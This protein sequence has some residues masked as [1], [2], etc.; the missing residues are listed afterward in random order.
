MGSIK[1]CVMSRCNNQAS[2][3]SRLMGR[4]YWQ[5]LWR[6]SI[7]T[8]GMRLQ[9]AHSESCCLASSLRMMWN[10]SQEPSLSA[11]A[12]WTLKGDWCATSSTR[13]RGKLRAL[14]GAIS[15]GYQQRCRSMAILTILSLPP[16]HTWSKEQF[17]PSGL[18]RKMDCSVSLSHRKAHEFPSSVCHVLDVLAELSV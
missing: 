4:W 13:E 17:A 2:L 7:H 1:A 14:C 10:A 6:P 9:V 8:L 15:E 5:N 3:S 18:V 12:L 16:S 11:S